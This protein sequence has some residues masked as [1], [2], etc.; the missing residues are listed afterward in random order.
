MPRLPG[1]GMLPS[2]R[3][4]NGPLGSQPGVRCGSLRSAVIWGYNAGGCL[5]LLVVRWLFAA[6]SSANNSAKWCQCG[7]PVGQYPPGAVRPQERQLPVISAAASYGCPGVVGARNLV[8][9]S[10]CRHGRLWS[11]LPGAMSVGRSV[12]WHNHCIAS[13]RHCVLQR[14]PCRARLTVSVSRL[15][16]IGNRSAGSAK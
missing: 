3:C 4:P 15:S 12:R 16:A 13:A 6:R 8:H 2:G 14:M 5:W 7:T 9:T 10:L 11:L 1:V